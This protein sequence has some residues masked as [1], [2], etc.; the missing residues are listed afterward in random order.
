MTKGRVLDTVV[1]SLRR[2]GHPVRRGEYVKDFIFDLVI[3]GRRPSVG[4]VLS[5]AT[6]AKNWT[7]AEHAAGHFLYANEK[8][9]AQAFAV[10][11]PPSEVSHR[12]ASIA[13]DRV[14]RWFAHERI[15]V[16]K[17]NELGQGSLPI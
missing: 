1:E 13:H 5:F 2:S 7:P 3:E 4:E 11:E 15:T 8:V 14:L 16:L 10:I 12:N 6:S 9:E 17:P